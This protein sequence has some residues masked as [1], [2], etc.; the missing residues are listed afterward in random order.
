MRT[1]QE[2]KEAAALEKS[3]SRG[4]HIQD[5]ASAYTKEVKNVQQDQNL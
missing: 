3:I 4:L 2:G 1:G 5:L